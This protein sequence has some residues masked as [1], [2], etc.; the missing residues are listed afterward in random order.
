VDGEK[1]KRKHVATGNKPPGGSRVGAGRP[2]GSRAVLPHRSV[3]AINALNVAKRR[4]G[5]VE[6]SEALNTLENVYSRVA[7]VLNERVHFS[8][9]P[10]VLKAATIVADAVAGPQKQAVE[11]SGKVTLE[12]LVLESLEEKP[13]ADGEAVPE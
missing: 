6:D 4:L 7:D 1:P 12:K 11:H 9:A 13:V 10:S 3:A 5:D 8:S 2:P